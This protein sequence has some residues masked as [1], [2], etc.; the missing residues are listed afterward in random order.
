MNIEVNPKQILI[1]KQDIIEFQ[2]N[3]EKYN[4]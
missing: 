4:P 2:D 1:D 3:N